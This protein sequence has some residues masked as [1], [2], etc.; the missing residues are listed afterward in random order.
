MRSGAVLSRIDRT[1]RTRSGADVV[2][3]AAV[4]HAR[5]EQLDC[6]STTLCDAESAPQTYAALRIRSTRH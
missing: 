3:F 2:D 5:M 6:A 1:N 4:R